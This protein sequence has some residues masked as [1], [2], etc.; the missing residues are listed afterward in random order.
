ME[1]SSVS[2]RLNGVAFMGGVVSYGHELKKRSMSVPEK[3]YLTY[4]RDYLVPSCYMCSP[5]TNPSGMNKLNTIIS[6]DIARDTLAYGISPLHL[7]INTM[8]CV[9]HIAYRLKLKQWA[10]K[11]KG[12]QQT[13]SQEKKRIQKELKQHLGIML[14]SPHKVLGLVTVGTQQDVFLKHLRL[15]PR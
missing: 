11:G 10:I 6:K 8:E 2:V 7:L 3:P 15:C 9:L 13:M 14:T 1:W 12:N 4:P 5:P